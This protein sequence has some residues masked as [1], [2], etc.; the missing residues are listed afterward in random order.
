MPRRSR[1]WAWYRTICRCP[2]TAMI[3][4]QGLEASAVSAPGCLAVTTGSIGRSLGI[5]TG[6]SGLPVTVTTAR[7]DLGLLIVTFEPLVSGAPAAIQ[8]RIVA[9][10]FSGILSPL[11]GM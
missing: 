4:A 1:L 11:G 10:S 8:A 5:A 9:M 3:G 7:L 6:P 2:P